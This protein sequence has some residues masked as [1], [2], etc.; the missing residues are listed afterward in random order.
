MGFSSN[1][2]KFHMFHLLRHKIHKSYESYVFSLFVVT[3]SVL[4]ANAP[5]PLWPNLS[6]DE[7]EGSARPIVSGSIFRKFLKKFR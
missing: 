5:P 7:L 6:G 3:T 4:T 1:M 2:L